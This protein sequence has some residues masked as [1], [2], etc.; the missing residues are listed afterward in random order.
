MNP[1]LFIEVQGFTRSLPTYLDDQGYRE[2]QSAIIA[3]PKAGD[4]IRATHGVRKL[5][6]QDARRKKGKR[7]GLRVIY[8]HHE[9]KDHVWMLAIYDKDEASDITPEYRRRIRE[10]IEEIHKR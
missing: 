7:G 3:D 5:R 4:V 8:F 9:A 2:M 6:W 1:V 10:L